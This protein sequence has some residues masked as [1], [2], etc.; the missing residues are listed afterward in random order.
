[1]S[2]LSE[3]IHEA[4]A[5]PPV[6]AE[7]YLHSRCE[8]N[9]AYEGEPYNLTIEIPGEGDE[10]YEGEKE[11]I[12]AYPKEESYYLTLAVVSDPLIGWVRDYRF[13]FTRERGDGKRG[14]KVKVTYRPTNESNVQ[15]EGD[16]IEIQPA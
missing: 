11:T 13:F 9:E 16:L 6:K 10:D 12:K 15:W 1:M 7:G 3:Q 2:T 14:H 5:K 4:L 8:E